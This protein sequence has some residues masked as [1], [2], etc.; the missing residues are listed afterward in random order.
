MIE[1]K[2]APVV[3]Y[4]IKLPKFISCPSPGTCDLVIC[5]FYFKIRKQ[6]RTISITL[7]FYGRKK[8]G[9]NKQA[10]ESFHLIPTLLSH[11]VFCSDPYLEYHVG[12]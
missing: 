10:L 12:G 11:H 2:I 5:F 8:F 7:I 6:E 4:G 9:C 1:T 3:A